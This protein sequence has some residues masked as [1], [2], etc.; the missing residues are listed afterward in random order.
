MTAILFD[1][2]DTLVGFPVASWDEVDR[3]SI[4]ALHAA[5]RRPL[6]DGTRLDGTLPGQSELLGAFRE[7]IV[8]A[9]RRTAP[10]LQELRAREVLRE[11]LRRSGILVSEAA[12]NGLERVWAEPRLAIRRVYP[13]VP[14]VIPALQQRGVRLGLISNIWVSGYIVREHLDALGLLRPFEAVVL[15]S[16]IGFV[17]PHRVLFEI[18]LEAMGVEPAEAWYVGDT[19]HADVA[20]AKGAG[21]GAVLVD[22]PASARFDPSPPADIPPYG[23]PDPD[24]VIRDLRGLLSLVS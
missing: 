18:A 10:R 6:A 22:R 23:G 24:A 4:Q 8:E 14:E 7:A 19:P 16:D 3:A 9:R 5:L 20:G 1:V 13:E 15:S 21:M 17:K 2:G 11:T 12:L